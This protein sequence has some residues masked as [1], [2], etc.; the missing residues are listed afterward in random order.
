M[1]RPQPVPSIE[2][3]V[4]HLEGWGI[5][6]VG[7]CSAET[8]TDARTA[9]HERKAAGLHADMGF[10]YRNPDR[11]TDPTQAVDGAWSI[12]VAARPYLTDTEPP[13]PGSD[14]GPH[15]RVGKYA[16]VDHYAPLREG[17]RSA[18]KLIRR[19]GHRA[20]AFA[21]DNSIVDRAV[22]Y[23]AGLGWYGKKREFADSWCWQLLCPRIDYYH[24]RLRVERTS[25]P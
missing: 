23:R 20:V 13:I 11:S 6:H 25:R 22:A 4:E 7:V 24:R 15:G 12:I 16:W 14:A 21:D 1:R 8:L 9:L 17:L 5:S 19:S 3:I 2:E 10:T 18:S